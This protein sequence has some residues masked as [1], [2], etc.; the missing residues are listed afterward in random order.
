MQPGI[1]ITGTLTEAGTGAPVKWVPVCA[2]EPVTEARVKCAESKPGGTYSIAGLPLGTYVTTFAVDVLEE[3]LDL[4]PDGYVRRYWAEKPTFAE[5]N[6]LDSFTP[7]IIPGINARLTPGPEGFPAAPV[8]A[9]PPVVTTTFV[10]I[11]PCRKGFH[12]RG[13]GAGGSCV[14]KHP[15]HRHHRHRHHRPHHAGKRRHAR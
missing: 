7:S 13:A 3:G 8:V 15:K 12:R 2:V 9:P 14:R 4:H 5:A 10:P 6:P 1:Q 11:K